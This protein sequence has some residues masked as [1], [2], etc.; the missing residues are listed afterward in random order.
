MSNKK[1]YQVLY[2]FIKGFLHL[3]GEKLY[4]IAFPAVQSAVADFLND[5][6]NQNCALEAVRAAVEQGLRGGEAWDL[7]KDKLVAQLAKSG[8]ETAETLIDTLLQ[9]AYCSVKY[10]VNEIITEGK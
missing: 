1:W 6:D 2:D 7:A 4:E 8:K 9:N 10:T 5:K 3:A